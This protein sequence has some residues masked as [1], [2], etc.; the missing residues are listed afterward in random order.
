[1]LTILPD[2]GATCSLTLEVNLLTGFVMVEAFAVV[3]PAPKVWYAM[4][5]VCCQS[6]RGIGRFCYGLK[7]SHER[8]GPKK[9]HAWQFQFD[10]NGVRARKRKAK[11]VFGLATCR[12]DS[13]AASVGV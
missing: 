1:M 8:W 12:S 10:A 9:E 11:G 13:H 3:L 2:F 5:D 4:V 7:I 6:Y